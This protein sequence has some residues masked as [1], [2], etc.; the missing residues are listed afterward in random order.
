MRTISLALELGFP[1][2]EVRVAL[3]RVQAVSP[4][5]EKVLDGAPWNFDNQLLLLK[6]IEGDEQPEN[7]DLKFCPFWIRLY[8][9]PFDS[10]S[11][12][13]VRKIIEKIG[14]VLEVENDELGWDKS[15]R[16]RVLIDTTR[17]IRIIQKIR[18][19]KGA[20][21]SVQF[22]YERLSTFCF[23]CGILGHREKDCPNADEDTD[24]EE[25]QWGLWLRASPRK[26]HEKLKEEVDKLRQKSQSLVFT[27]KPETRKVEGNVTTACIPLFSPHMDKSPKERAAT[28]QCVTDPL[29]NKSVLRTRSV[30]EGML[31]VENV[32]VP[33]VVKGVRD[34]IELDI[35]ASN[36]IREEYEK[37][38]NDTD[39]GV[40]QGM[41]AEE[42]GMRENATGTITKSTKKWK[43]L[44]RMDEGRKKLYRFEAM[45]LSKP[46]CNE[47]IK[48]AWGEGAGNAPHNRISLCSNALTKWAAKSFGDMKKK[49][50]ALEIELQEA[51]GGHMDAATLQRVGVGN[52]I[53]VW[54]DP[55]VVHDGKPIVLQMPEGAD[56]NMLVR[57]LMV[58][59]GREWD[60]AKHS[61]LKSN[62][63][64]A[65]NHSF[66]ALWAWLYRKC[67]GE[68]LSTMAALM[69]AAWRCRNLTIFENER[70]NA[71]L[72][73]AGY[74][75]LVHDYQS[76]AKKCVSQ[77]RKC[78]CASKY[79]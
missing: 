54:K 16:A 14:V 22:K 34:T 66:A 32:V 73:A 44:V 12:D 48:K 26:G 23:L 74:C 59:G 33:T 18:N 76:Y 47:V 51:Q 13:D 3:L 46:N 25:K 11:D 68:A 27:H 36:N 2:S 79:C 9:L 35:G 63:I 75:R 1:S 38:D 55:W 4:S 17:P 78:C 30:R 37:E 8:N 24:V 19:K 49:I 71:I 15:R 42:S 77:S 57:E 7:I 60:D 52:N 61:D 70:P 40:L 20:V 72:L 64:D 31:G 21:T 56:E 28:L 6:E 53:R 43:K 5:P 67:S 41:G 45:W 50:R 29:S 10:R 62:L 65:P 39:T 58:E 69:W